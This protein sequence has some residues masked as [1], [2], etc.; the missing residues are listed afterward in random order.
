MSKKT[1]ASKPTVYVTYNEH[2]DRVIEDTLGHDGPWSGFR[3]DHYS[4]SLGGV[5]EKCP[6]CDTPYWDEVEVSDLSSGDDIPSVLHIV[7]VRYSTGSTFGHSEG[8]GSIVAAF[9]TSEAAI[10]VRDKIIEGTYK[11]RY[12]YNEW[13]G[14]FESLESV[15]IE[16]L[17]KEFLKEAVY[18]R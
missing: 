9:S 16:T 7:Y 4:F 18:V 14:Y 17:S 1:K 3:E 6:S 15:H 12:G 10:K 13:E 2:C 5:Y 11:G 8:R